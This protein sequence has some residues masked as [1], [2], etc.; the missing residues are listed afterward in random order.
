MSRASVRVAHLPRALAAAIVILVLLLA[1]SIMVYVLG[2]ATTNVE[3]ALPDAR[4]VSSKLYMYQ[5]LIFGLLAI[6]LALGL[7]TLY[8]IYTTIKGE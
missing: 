8:Y 4:E 1:T 3:N 2:Q 6:S 5:P 7:M